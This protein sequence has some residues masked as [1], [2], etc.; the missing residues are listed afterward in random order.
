[1]IWSYILDFYAILL[2]NW[3]W[4][5]HVGGIGKPIMLQ[6]TI[7]LLFLMSTKYATN[8]KSTVENLSLDVSNSSKYIL[9]SISIPISLSQYPFLKLYC[10]KFTTHTKHT[11]C[12]IIITWFQ[13]WSKQINT[14]SP[15]TNYTLFSHLVIMS[16]NDLHVTRSCLTFY[17]RDAMLARVI[18]IVTCLS[19]CP[20]ICLSVCHAPVLCQNEEN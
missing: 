16:I 7:P 20:S 6:K 17:P 9:I 15:I 10:L 2:D 12:I 1:M 8:N 18:A 4:R 13:Y 5:S 11:P 3:V 19:V 14:Y